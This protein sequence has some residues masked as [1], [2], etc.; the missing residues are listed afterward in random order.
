MSIWSASSV[1]PSSTVELSSWT[2]KYCTNGETFFCGDDGYQ[3][4][5]ST[6][7]QSF[8]K[9]TMS[10]VTKSGRKY[11]LVGE[12]GYHSDASYVWGRVANPLGWD[13]KQDPSIDEKQVDTLVERLAKI[14]EKKNE[15][16]E[17]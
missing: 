7:I 6:A 16:P 17:E 12:P 4:R 11:V 5:V 14:Q 10:G 2:I 8:D 1:N 3:G 13:V 15:T 9:E